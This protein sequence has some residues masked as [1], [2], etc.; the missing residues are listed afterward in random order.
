MQHAEGDR[1]CVSRRVGCVADIAAALDESRVRSPVHPRREKPREDGE[2]QATDAVKLT[3]GAATFLHPGPF[4]AQILKLVVAHVDEMRP[5]RASQQRGE[6]HAK[7][8]PPSTLRCIR[9]E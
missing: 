5:E 9:Q 2:V 1:L 4:Q 3:V 7:L 8:N 6:D